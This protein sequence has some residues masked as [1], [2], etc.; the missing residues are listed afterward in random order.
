MLIEK[1]MSGLYMGENARRILLSFAR[2][3]SLFNGH[4]PDKLCEPNSFST[5]GEFARTQHVLAQFWSTAL[6]QGGRQT[7][8]FALVPLLSSTTRLVFGCTL[9]LCAVL[10]PCRPV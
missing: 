4:V 8:R 3:A 2:H 5:A 9:T 10:L 7:V 6:C 1:L